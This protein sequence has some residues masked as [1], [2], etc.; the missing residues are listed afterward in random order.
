MAGRVEALKLDGVADLYD[1]AGANASIHIRNSALR[2]TVRNDFCTRG[3]DDALVA[4]CMITV[5]VCIQDLRNR[6]AALSGDR[7][8]FFVVE[9]VDS[10]SIT[11]LG[12]GDKVIEISISVTC[13]NLFNDH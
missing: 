8:T 11:G 12:T 1:V 10:K 13:P 6:P 7:K 5:F 2:I 4:A 3:T 9:R